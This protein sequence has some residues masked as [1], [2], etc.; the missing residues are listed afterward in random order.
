MSLTPIT[1][2]PKVAKNAV[3]VVSRINPKYHFPG[4]LP[5][6][7][8]QIRISL[9][10]PVKGRMG[11]HCPFAYT[12]N[13][14][15]DTYEPDAEVFKILWEARRYLYTSPLREVVDWIN[16]KT[17]KLNYPYTLSHGG[18]RNIMILRPPYEECIL[19]T[20]QKEKILQSI[21]QWNQTTT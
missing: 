1:K 15:T 5:L 13:E 11:G 8:R 10:L 7:E 21:C 19:P 14:A 2:E 4:T 17:E 16:F 6:L 18:L 3:D 12:Y 9:G 20:E